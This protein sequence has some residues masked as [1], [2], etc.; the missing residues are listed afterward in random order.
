MA[1]PGQL[2]GELRAAVVA[3]GQLVVAGYGA[4]I[5]RALTLC[6][7]VLGKNILKGEYPATGLVSGSIPIRIVR[8]VD[9]HFIKSNT[10]VDIRCIGH[11]NWW[12]VNRY[13][14]SARPIADRYIEELSCRRVLGKIVV[15]EKPDINRG[16]HCSTASVIVPEDPECDLVLF[17]IGCRPWSKVLIDHLSAR[18]MI[19]KNICDR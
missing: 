9:G 4:N 12:R 11:A 1:Y 16:R 19:G 17:G 10:I 8:Q 15:V 6:R 7:L 2:R 18:Y 3:K 5:G 13:S 14:L